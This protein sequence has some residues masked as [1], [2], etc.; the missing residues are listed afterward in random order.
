M[1]YYIY[2]AVG[3][4]ATEKAEM[5]LTICRRQYKLFILGEDYTRAQLE[6]MIPGTNMVPHIYHGFNY[7][8]GINELHDYLYSEL[9]IEKG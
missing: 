6:K 5:L 7:I 2:G 1:P 4:K 9:R 8:G 3:S